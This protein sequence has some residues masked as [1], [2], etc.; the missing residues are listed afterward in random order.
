MHRFNICLAVVLLSCS[1]VK[2]PLDRVDL[3]RI[4][5]TSINL[6][7]M[8]THIDKLKNLPYRRTPACRPLLFPDDQFCQK[9]VTIRLTVHDTEKSFQ[10]LFRQSFV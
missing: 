7:I 2:T 1:G 4:H 3:I 5:E 8:A 6:R 9:R 10:G